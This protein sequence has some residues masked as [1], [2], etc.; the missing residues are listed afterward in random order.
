MER[1]EIL[2]ELEI[3]LTQAEEMKGILYVLQDSLWKGEEGDSKIRFLAASHLYNMIEKFNDELR[4]NLKAL[5]SAVK[6]E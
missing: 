2:A 6:F 5:C 3:L 4:L 1:D